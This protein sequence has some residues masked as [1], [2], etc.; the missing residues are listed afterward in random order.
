MLEDARRKWAEERIFILKILPQSGRRKPNPEKLLTAIAGD[1]INNSR[2]S[3]KQPENRVFSLNIGWRER[4]VVEGEGEVNLGA[5]DDPI[6]R[7]ADQRP[8]LIITVASARCPG[9]QNV[10]ETG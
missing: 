10:T 1:S 3:E 8:D 7:A 2:G 9:Y 5:A 4:R 6:V